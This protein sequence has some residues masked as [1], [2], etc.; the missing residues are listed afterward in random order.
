MLNN[1]GFNF[2]LFCSN[3]LACFTDFRASTIYIFSTLSNLV[4]ASC[5]L[6]LSFQNHQNCSFSTWFTKFDAF[7]FHLFLIFFLLIPNA[8]STSAIRSV[9]KKVFISCPNNL[10][11]FQ[12][13]FLI[14]NWHCK[15]QF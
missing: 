13:L 12:P 11:L 2:F 4:F 7:I 10:T 6:A 5:C 15:I 3:D 14:K 8:I 9:Y 1:S